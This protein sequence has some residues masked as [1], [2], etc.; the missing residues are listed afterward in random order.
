MTNAAK[1]M[2]ANS[3]CGVEWG[4]IESTSITIYPWCERCS[5]NP[6]A[7]CPPLGIGTPWPPITQWWPYPQ[8]VFMPQWAPPQDVLR[9]AV[10]ALI[11]AGISQKDIE[12]VIRGTEAIVRVKER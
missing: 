11:A 10:A 1:I 5:C 7:C 8:P 4:S 6:C 9:D 3:H 2:V 12:I